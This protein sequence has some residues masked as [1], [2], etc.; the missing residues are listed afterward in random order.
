[1]VA[2]KVKVAM[3][4]QRSPAHNAKTEAPPKPPLPSASSAKAPQKP[5]FSRSFGVYFPRSSAQVQPRPPD[6]TELLRLVEELRERE[7]RLKTELLEQKLLKESVAILPV[8]ENEITT[9]EGEIERCLKK[10]EGLEGENERLMREVEE[11]NAKMEE[12]RREGEGKLKALEAEVAELKKAASER[13]RAES[14]ALW[15]ETGESD[16]LSSSQ[17]FQ[18]LI[19]ASGKSNLIKN[20]RKGLKCTEVVDNHKPEVSDLKRDEGEPERPR[21]SRCNSEE[22]A[23]TSE[24]VRS[25]VPRVPKPPPKPSC[26][27]SSSSTSTSPTSPS[28]TTPENRATPE[29]PAPPPPPTLATKSVPPPPPPPSKAA[30]PPPPPPP[31]RKGLKP[32]PAKVRRVPEVV[33]F[34][35]SLMRRDSRRESGSGV[36]DVPANTNARD[37]IGEIENRS[38][39]LLAVSYRFRH[40]ITIINQSAIGFMSVPRLRRSFVFTDALTLPPEA[41]LP[42][43]DKALFE[44][45]IHIRHKTFETLFFYSNFIWIHSGRQR[46]KRS[47]MDLNLGHDRHYL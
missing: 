1:M 5:V 37:M 41:Y 13:S 28:T 47:K 46:Q 42:W 43:K 25:R 20:L 35:H 29:A 22:I 45:K 19:D 2:G 40:S 4:L 18:G 3:G 10:I 17:R 44:F 33:E 7:S 26:S 15:N 38:A 16:E 8:L 27:S 6:V 11:L 39:H 30:P 21:H 31:L 12:E 9:K 32:M 34:Y 23:E 14:K 24:P 36:P